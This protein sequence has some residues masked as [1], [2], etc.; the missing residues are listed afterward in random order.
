MQTLSYLPYRIQSVSR[1][2]LPLFQLGYKL[3]QYII[4]VFSASHDQIYYFA[5]NYDHLNK[6]SG[7]LCLGAGKWDIDF[8]TI[9]K[10]NASSLIISET[11]H[12]TWHALDHVYLL[13][14]FFFVLFCGVFF[15]SFFFLC[16]NSCPGGDSAEQQDIPHIYILC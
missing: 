9:T 5:L 16:F 4:F 12:I 14:R 7:I 13:F 3:Y 2:I 15:S 1:L 11:K 8:L 6:A 10:S